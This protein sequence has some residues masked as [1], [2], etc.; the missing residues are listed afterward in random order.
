[1]LNQQKTPELESDRFS[2]LSP[3]TYGLAVA[4]RE[5]LPSVIVQHGAKIRVYP[6]KVGV[7]VGRRGRTE[8]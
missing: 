8:T 4:D 5:N 6:T 1:M 7:G 3:V 2:G